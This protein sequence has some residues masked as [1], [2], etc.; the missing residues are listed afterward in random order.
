MMLSKIND[1]S[2]LLGVLSSC[3]LMLAAL[4]LGAAEPLNPI[5]IDEWPNPLKGHG[6][7]PFATGGD[8]I[9]FVGQG[10]H[11]LARFTPS[12]GKFFKRDLP[13]SAGP[14]NLIV[15]SD[16]I[17]WY[18]GNLVG[19]IGRYDPKTDEITRIP[20]PDPAARDPHTLI[21]DKGQQH[22]FFTVQGGNF[23]GKLTIADRSVQLTPVATPRARP[24]GIK[25][26]PDGTPWVVLF[27]TNKL[28]S[29]NPKTLEL[30]EYTIP[31]QGARPRRLEI[32]S[33]GRIWYADYARGYLGAY[34]PRDRSFEEWALPS[35]AAS[36]P[37]G[38]A[39][40]EQGRV[41]V[42]ESGVQPNLFVGFD[43]RAE[44]IFSVTRIP[45][46]AGSV[47]HMDYHLPTTSVWFGTDAETI[48]RARLGKQ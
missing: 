33:D 15:G 22:I 1:R 32:T 48:G 3:C 42:V 2:V 43:T 7:D 35:G 24:Y 25:L 40:D 30:T 21:F 37:Y 46:G 11:Y 17:V 38:M 10:G 9:W 14:H 27:G 29:L 41:W 6:R 13:D 28:A 26:A 39:S 47:R 5:V 34:D 45:S 16:G 44:K 31:A 23:V 4:P 20:M 12:T 19:N 18:S 8:A 36:R